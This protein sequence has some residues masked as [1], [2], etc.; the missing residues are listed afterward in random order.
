MRFSFPA[1]S[2]PGRRTWLSS[3]SR[4]PSSFELSEFKPASADS[5]M[6]AFF[7]KLLDTAA[8]MV[9]SVA[10]DHVCKMAM[11]TVLSRCTGIAVHVFD[12]FRP[13]QRDSIENTNGMV[14]QYLPKGTV[15]PGNRQEQIETIA[16][17]INSRPIRGLG[18]RAR[19][20]SIGSRSAVVRYTS[21][22]RS[23]RLRVLQA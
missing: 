7:D 13:W 22:P 15:L 19:C 20:R 11:H 23:T 8:P 2:T 9:L 3:V 12:P 14:R 1:I 4:W 10:Y 16:D 21:P 17:Q 6:Q 5:L 18:G